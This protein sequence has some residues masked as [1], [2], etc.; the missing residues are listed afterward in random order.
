[1]SNK[2]TQDNKL[3]AMNIAEIAELLRSAGLDVVEFKSSLV[4]TSNDTVFS[5]ASIKALFK[6][7]KVDTSKFSYASLDGFYE[8]VVSTW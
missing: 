5:L 4:M 1:M 7:N 6:I 8:L 3:V 2:T